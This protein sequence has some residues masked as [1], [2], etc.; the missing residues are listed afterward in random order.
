MN[1]IDYKEILMI[2]ISHIQI[3]NDFKFIIVIGI[4]NIIITTTVVEIITNLLPS[5]SHDPL[6]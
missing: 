2:I 4:K 5:L 6:S 1:K 3:L